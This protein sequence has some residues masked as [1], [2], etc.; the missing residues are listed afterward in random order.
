MSPENFEKC[1]RNGGKVRTISGKNERYGLKDGQYRHICILN[2][3]SFMG[4]IKQ[5]KDM[6]KD[7]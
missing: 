1:V 7:E 5:K 3:E 4:E 2:G 6:T